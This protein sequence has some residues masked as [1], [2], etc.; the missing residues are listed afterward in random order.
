M[1]SHRKRRPGPIAF[2]VLALLSAASVARTLTWPERGNAATTYLALFAL[3]LIPY[4]AVLWRPV[5]PGPLTHLYFAFQSAVILGLLSLNPAIDFITSL[6]PI[7][8]YQA[9]FL[10]SGRARW[11]WVGVIAIQTPLSLMILFDPL[12]GLALGLSAMAFAIV[13]PAFA[14]LNE[15]L[16]NAGEQSRALLGDLVQ[17]HSQL[18]A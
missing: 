11:F 12:Q 3:F 18:Q 6:Y 7:L 17:R 1:N 14:M 16:E 8:A 2:A 10:L 5:L 15:E 13:V 9:A 4:F